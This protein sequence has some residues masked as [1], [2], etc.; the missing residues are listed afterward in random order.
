[1]LCEE[2]PDLSNS[3]FNSVD[4]GALAL[5]NPKALDTCCHFMATLFRT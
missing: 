2:L 1:M 5:Y 3:D 4:Y